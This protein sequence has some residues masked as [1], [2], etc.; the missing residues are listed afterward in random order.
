MQFDFDH[1]LKAGHGRAYLMAKEDPERYREAIMNAC[2]KDYTYA[3]VFEGSRAYFT[4]DLISLYEDPA[5]FI[6]AAKESFNSP[7][8][9]DV[10]NEIKYLS[11]LM[12]E[13]G[14]RKTVLNK[15]FSLW[16]K[17]KTTSYQHLM[18]HSS[19]LLSNVEYLAIKLVDVASDSSW[20]IADNIVNDM[21]K[22]YLTL[23]KDARNE[24]SW[25][26]STLED[27][28]GEDETRE[29]LLK[30]AETSEEAKAFCDK[31]LKYYQDLSGG[32]T[33][34]RNSLT[35]SEVVKRL[36]ADPGLKEMDLLEM[37]IRSLKD[38]EI[39]ELA[40]AAVDADS[41]VLRAQIVSVFDTPR[42]TWPFDP[43]YLIKWCGEGDP[44][45][46]EN[47]HCTMTD[48]TAGCIRDYALRYL[49]NSFDHYCLI[50]LIKNY[51]PGDEEMILPMLKNIEITDENEGEWHG[52]GCAILDSYKKLPVSILMWVYDT[53]LCSYC[54]KSLVEDLIELNALPDSV[55]D[56]CMW[57]ANPD[58]RKLV[59]AKEE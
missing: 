30:L 50:M 24:F 52:I 1:Y 43:E 59:T 16:E 41:A 33:V 36:K 47:C 20:K 29:H 37:G 42:F 10:G 28:Y 18:E 55:R 22:W 2:R 32:F 11:D 5:P 15:Y 48:I 38:N 27:K 4:A 19:H 56:E 34:K 54:R 39:V 17:I 25:F 26:Y 6:D 8:I 40:K 14:Q 35:A 53:T 13:F 49:Q 44:E 21:G 23:D 58:L 9:D 45:L 57:D 51:E 3:I 12:I 31:D 7:E 46:R